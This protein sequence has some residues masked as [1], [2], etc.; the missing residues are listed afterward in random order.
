MTLLP[1]ATT[2][3]DSLEE[4]GD[5]GTGSAELDAPAVAAAAA[6]AASAAASAGACSAD[7]WAVGCVAS[8]TSDGMDNARPAP[9][10]VPAL[11]IVGGAFPAAAVAS[12]VPTG[13]L[14]VSDGSSAA[15]LTL[16]PSPAA[17]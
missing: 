15:S 9:P 10:A 13:V 6:A 8:P 12:S 2:L 17:D 5:L 16:A 1:G 14:I 3:G 4:R 7:V 11:T